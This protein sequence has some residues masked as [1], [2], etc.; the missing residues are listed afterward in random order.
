[1][2]SV[3]HNVTVNVIQKSDWNKIHVT[4]SIVII[5]GDT[6]NDWC[7]Q[8]MLCDIF[9]TNAWSITTSWLF[10]LS[11]KCSEMISSAKC[12]WHSHDTFALKQNHVCVMSTVMI[13]GETQTIGATITCLITVW[14][15]NSWLATW[16][17]HCASVIITIVLGDMQYH[18]PSIFQECRDDYWQKLDVRHWC[19]P[20]PPKHDH[21]KAC[22]L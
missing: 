9:A 16:S 10:L 11:E 19:S 22:L 15:T 17:R 8:C 14:A 12:H 7:D 6:Q 13:R 18:T 2:S 3:L 20:R 4:Y 5:R 21:S 1:M